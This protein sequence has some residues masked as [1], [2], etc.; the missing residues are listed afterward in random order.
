MKYSQSDFSGLSVP[1]HLAKT[2]KPIKDQFSLFTLYPEFSKSIPE[3]EQ[4][5][6]LKYIVYMYDCNT[7]LKSISDMLTRKAKAAELAG[8]K[9]DNN[10]WPLPVLQMFYGQSK[11]ANAMMI[12]YAR[13]QQNQDWFILK[14][15]EEKLF[16]SLQMLV[17]DAEAN[18]KTKD[19][20]F[21][22]KTLR[23]EIA[24]LMKKIANDDNSK[25]LYID[26][27][28]Q[29]DSEINNLSV[30]SI[31]YAM[32]EGEDILKKYNPYAERTATQPTTKS[33]KRTKSKETD[34]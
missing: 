17:D 18:E 30:E 31:A 21:A 10:H 32:S 9:S 33:G 28:N 29:I 13:V 19:Q 1:V 7:P 23:D 20:L 14:T 6:L 22:I 24:Q 11:V 34:F 4:D 8:I 16:K 27:S 26:I 12:R 15:F 3:I 2:D 25:Q 5:S